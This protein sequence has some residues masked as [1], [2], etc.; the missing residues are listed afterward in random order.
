MV[1][2]A[3]EAGQSDFGENY[4]QDALS[5]ISAVPDATWHYIGAI[6]SNKTREIATHF[7]WVHTV[8]SEKIARR[9]NAQRAG[10]TLPLN[11]MLQVNVN[12]EPGKS[13]VNEDDLPA[14]VE[15]ALQFDHLHLR[16]LMAIPQRS[17]DVEKQRTN[18]IKLAELLASIQRQFCLSGFDELSMGMSADLEAAVSAGATW[19]RI[20][21]AIFGER[22]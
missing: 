1:R 21:T 4:L 10:S 15:S 8:A 7:D 2:E 9:L 16:G 17:D 6:Q 20:G 19:I 14:L 3:I 12:R 5:K 18:F 22:H 11:I 13:G